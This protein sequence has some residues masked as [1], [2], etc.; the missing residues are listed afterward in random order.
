[1]GMLSLPD[2]SVKRPIAVWM[3]Y[4]AIILMG[5]IA[6]KMLP[7]EMM[8]NVSFGDIT[9]NIDVRGGMPASEVEKRITKLVE[10]AVGSVTHLKDIIAISK[11]GN[12][13]VILEF[14]PGTNMEF[15][16]LD[17][18]EKFN[19]I[20]N[21]LPPEIEKPVI[22]KYEYMD[23][24]IMIIA[25]TSPIRSPEQLR[26]IVDE[27]VRDRIQRIEG[28]ANA[29]IAGGRESKV[30][31]E[32]DQ[33]K[34]QSYGLPINRVVDT[35]NLNNENSLAGEIKGAR[36]KFLVRTIGEFK[37][38]DDI[39]NLAIATTSKGSVIRVKDVATVKDSYLDP[40]SFSRMNANP[41]ISIYVQ[42]E[43]TANTVKIS[44]IV[45]E[46]I[47]KLNRILEKDIQINLT[48][49]QADVIQQAV[50]QVQSSLVTGALL[51]IAVLLIFLAD[52]RL[53]FIIGACVPISLLLT[54]ILMYFFK[55]SINVI[56]LS[57]LALGVGM[58][59]DNS[60]VVLDNA[61]KKRDKFVATQHPN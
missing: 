12:A 60:I 49:N 52:L 27:K 5:L 28:V 11:E 7:V 56:S 42:K 9:I 14:E 40:V 35:I 26:K 3:F 10:E 46:E 41:V 55:L 33:R 34:L 21:K 17:V 48:F 44:K 47:Q 4:L 18:R 31:I 58:L 38:L 1:M 16:A 51:A 54:F 25:L 23:V 22:A 32:V 6:F 59:V 29:E 8:P 45:K 24:P 61:F 36:N 30:I 50:S 15:A 13:T 20:R 19:R 37:N 39:A 2:L 43:S 57:G 53:V